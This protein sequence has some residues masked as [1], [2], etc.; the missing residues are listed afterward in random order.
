MCEGIGMQA[1]PV[2]FNAEQFLQT[3]IAETDVP[4]K[5]VQQGKLT[6]LVRRLERDGL[7]PERTDKPVR[8]RG[9]Q[10]SML[11]KESDSL[12]AFPRLDDDL[13]C[14]RVEPFLPLLDLAGERPV[15]EPAIS[16]LE[17][18]SRFTATTMSAML[19]TT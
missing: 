16:R 3:N 13:V 19:S 12:C 1:A 11:I 6:W 2:D 7:E 8:V 17:P 5:M 9:V 15:G 4:A 14:T 18:S 10:V